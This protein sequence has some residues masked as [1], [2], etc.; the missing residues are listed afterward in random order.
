MTDHATHVTKKRIAILFDFDD[1]LAPDSFQRL[2][3][4]YGIE[5]KQ[6]EREHINP[7]VED[8]W[9]KLLARMYC[10]I[11]E[12]R[13][14]P[15][16]P[17]TRDLMRQI[18]QE[19]QFF[20]GVPAMFDRVRRTAAAIVPGI[21]VQFYLLSSGLLQIARNSAIAD[22]FT[23][24]WGCTFAYDEAGAICF[25]K[26][27]ITHAEKVRYVLQ[28]VKGVSDQSQDG[29]PTDVYREVPAEDLHLAM[30]QVIYLGDG[31]SDLPVFGLL[32]DSGGVA[33]AIYKG[34]SPEDWRSYDSLDEHQR[35]E[36]LAQASYAED[37]ELM[38][39]LSLAVESICKRI[40]LG[41]LSQ[42]E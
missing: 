4:H 32:N 29:R 6:F 15:D 18:G 2:L 34:D 28:V 11:E 10:L 26:Q 13:R 37:S 20:E 41:L 8:G 36:N 23:E 25:P 30:S 9:D 38:Q 1:T 40:A 22:Q 31:A 39:S 27:L 5:L 42:G 19:T 33:L 16:D 17:V 7:L 3:G 24:M 35:V 14:H 21:D 12:S